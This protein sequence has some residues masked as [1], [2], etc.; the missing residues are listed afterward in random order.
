MGLQIPP[1]AQT[2]Q[3]RVS[4]LP[5]GMGVLMKHSYLLALTLLTSCSNDA[6]TFHFTS[7]RSSSG[8]ENT[9]T[10]IQAANSPVAALI[11][12]DTY[13]PEERPNGYQA[14]FD[15]IQGK[16]K[17]PN[18]FNI[19]VAFGYSD[20]IDEHF[21]LVTDSFTQN[22]LDRTLTDSCKYDGQGFCEFRLISGGDDEI[23]HYSRQFLTPDR[24]MTTVN[25][26]TMNSSYSARNSENKTIYKV[27]QDQK[28]VA[29]RNFYGSAMANSDMVF[30][31]G[32][33]RDG[34]GPDFA[35]PRENGSGTVNY[36]WYRTNKPGLKHLLASL[37]NA[38]RK[39]S[40]LGL[41]SCA[42]RGHFLR[43]LQ[44]HAPGSPIILSTRVVEASKT[45]TAM[46]RTLESVLNF[47]CKE[48]LSDR[49]SGTSFVVD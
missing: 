40:Q 20:T 9:T 47:E 28:T 43:A 38:A 16:L 45:R 19:S 46:L 5:T 32:H 36:P 18:V 15:R 2:T 29:V 12:N 1:Q 26:Y 3:A 7:S 41:F 44:Q 33:S 49:L 14:C 35:P 13:Q 17:S 37:D 25:V 42:S 31:E 34:G 23:N 4:K 22:T 30:Y 21:D 24:Q 11:A 27:K 6:E 10:A 39:P 8:D 48:D